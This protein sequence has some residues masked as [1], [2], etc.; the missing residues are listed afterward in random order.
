M[1]PLQY[2]REI[3][4]SIAKKLDIKKWTDW[5]MINPSEV[6]KNGGSGILWQYEGSLSKGKEEQN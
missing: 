6:S 5:G 2:Q 4:E 3:F 1:H